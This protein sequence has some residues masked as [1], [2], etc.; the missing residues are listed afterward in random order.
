MTLEEAQ[1]IMQTCSTEQRMAASIIAKHLGLKGMVRSYLLGVQ[2]GGTN[3][4]VSDDV[5]FSMLDGPTSFE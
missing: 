4:K 1:R 2:H 5:L 3:Q